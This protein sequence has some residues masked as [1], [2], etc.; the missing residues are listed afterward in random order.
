MQPYIFEKLTPSE[1]VKLDIYNDAFSYVFNNKDICNVA[2]S[3]PYSSGKSSLLRTYEK[4]NKMKF[5][6]LSLAKFE[7]NE[8]NNLH[9]DSGEKSQVRYSAKS[10]IEGKLIN[11]LVQKINPEKV[12]MTCFKTKSDDDFNNMNTTKISIYVCLIILCIFY[13]CFNTMFGKREVFST[14]TSDFSYACFLFA[15][16]VLVYGAVHTVI[17]LQKKDF[18]ISKISIQG[19]EIEILGDSN[20]SFFDKYLN[21]VLYLFENVS[22]EVIVFEDIDRFGCVDV[23]ERLR[24]INQLVNVRKKRKEGQNY[25][26]I[27]FFYLLKDDMFL[28]KDRTK[29][30]DFMI[31]VIPVIDSS[32]SY[33]K[34]KESL[35]D[36]K[37]YEKFDEKFLREISIYI[38]DYRILKNIC[39]EFKIY[40]GVLNRIDQ[41]IE[42]MFAIIVY[43]NLFPKDFA[44]LQLKRG[45]VY[46]IFSSRKKILDEDIK[47]KKSE[48][49][50]IQARIANCENECL[51]DKKELDTIAKERKPTY[52]R[53]S[54]SDP[55]KDKEYDEWYA[56]REQAINDKKEDNL[57][58]LN[59][60]IEE[61]KQ[62]LEVL[63]SGN[64]CDLINDDNE[65]KIFEGE[66]IEVY[67]DII[68]N[69][70]FKLLC[71]LIKN[72]YVD[73]SY[74]DFMT[75][76]YDN[77]LSINDKKFIRRIYDG[78]DEMFDYKLNNVP[79]I[80]EYL[81][82]AQMKRK[83]CLNFDLV[84]ELLN[85][86]EKY[87]K[88]TKSM[89]E[90]LRKNR[91]YDFVFA[92]VKQ[93]KST[94]EFVNYINILWPEL[95]VEAM[96]KGKIEDEMLVVFSKWSLIA[97]QDDVLENINQ[98]GKLRIFI[99]KHPDYI[100]DAFDEEDKVLNA[101]KTLGIKFKSIDITQASPYMYKFVYENNLYEY[102]EA[103]VLMYLNS[104]YNI[105]EEDYAK[106]KIL[107]SIYSKQEEY[108]WKYTMSD[109]EININVLMDCSDNLISD[110]EQTILMVLN[111]ENITAKTKE[112]YLNRLTTK[113][114]NIEDIKENEIKVAVI[115][116]VVAEISV[117]NIM[118][119][120]L[121]CKN[122]I[123]V[124][125]I[126][127]IN[128]KNGKVGFGNYEQFT[129]VNAKK[130]IDDCIK[131][132]Q[133]GD[134]AYKEIVEFQ[135]LPCERFDITGI[136]KSHFCILMNLKK[137]V[138]NKANLIF[139][140]KN[141]E[142]HVLD[143]IRGNISE[144]FAL[145]VEPDVVCVQDMSEILSWDE[146]IIQTKLEQLTR[147][148]EVLSVV[149]KQ[150]PNEIIDEIL[151]NHYDVNDFLYLCQNYGS[152]QESSKDIIYNIV[153]K[154]NLKFIEII[155]E[156][157]EQL[158]NRIISDE[159]VSDEHKIKF[160]EKLIPGL[161][162]SQLIELLKKA[163]F[164]EVKRAL[165]RKKNATVTVNEINEK[166][167]KAMQGYFI[168]SYEVVEDKYSLTL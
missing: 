53:N 153:L 70:Y 62:E 66:N 98:D 107:S 16:I 91:R 151:K 166:L 117:D 89:I 146:I 50:K 64:F 77:S 85:N 5:L 147:I 33:N 75:H 145:P 31:P 57:F 24:E 167:L 48:I 127:F 129:E 115:K 79:L 162:K 134:K 155:R 165:G 105:Q 94:K 123:T 73:E 23:F 121:L 99:E 10:I 47:Q 144:Y 52:Y 21:E 13:F 9:E 44:E 55:S 88:Y 132:N 128:E 142:F 4:S 14:L 149:G 12:P 106:K 118:H 104:E 112:T 114:S 60:Q 72:G 90:E 17:N 131:N 40:Y 133:L 25:K 61:K 126:H 97:V 29:F 150:Y 101:I 74:N 111:D 43:K 18:A 58:S 3:G 83:E 102:N 45:Y 87:E 84:T 2:I 51:E 95:F 68:E 100:N 49:E 34:I 42:K 26:P 76:F 148:K 11:Q 154:N 158:K 7:R 19:N 103:N 152:Y 156:A 130:F 137:I 82:V 109:L 22:E 86:K 161:E 65:K 54:Y 20:D 46:Q 120:Y 157:D 125:L 143:F 92:F 32:N 28:N 122:V 36:S 81:S 78:A 159:K 138:M 63:Y 113:I 1:G 116:A 160:I 35:E 71:F 67:K 80:I 27:R 39:N 15:S 139:V 8:E 119:Y 93:K 37:L 163:D 164:I 136:S 59:R 168:E 140:R 6:Y 135:M 41:K 110:D 124:E 108:L 30:F 141:Y 56:R 69:H 38:D 96:E